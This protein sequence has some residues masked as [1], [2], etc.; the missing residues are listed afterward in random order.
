MSIIPIK[1]PAQPIEQPSNQVV[2]LV[3]RL[4]RFMLILGVVQ[5]LVGLAYLF[6]FKLAFEPSPWVDRFAFQGL[7][8][9]SLCLCLCSAAATLKVGRCM[10]AEYTMLYTI[11][12]GFPFIGTA[13]VF[14][15][16]AEIREYLRTNGLTVGVLGVSPSDV[17]KLMS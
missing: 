6:L 10:N 7:I 3:A 9:L 17:E 5:A 1:P 13:L 16:D 4:H 11:A 8:G 15:L 12:G 14:T 2:C